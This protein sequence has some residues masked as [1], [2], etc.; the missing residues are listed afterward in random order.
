MPENNIITEEEIKKIMDMKG[1]KN[2]RNY[3][4]LER[5]RRLRRLNEAKRFRRPSS[6]SLRPSRNRSRGRML[7]GVSVNESFGTRHYG[8]KPFSHEDIYGLRDWIMIS[9]EEEGD[10]RFALKKEMRQATLEDLDD[11]DFSYSEMGIFRHIDDDG[12]EYYTLAGYEENGEFENIDELI[13]TLS[14]VEFDSLYSFRYW[15]GHNQIIEV[16]D[17]DNVSKIEAFV[18]DIDE[19]TIEDFVKDIDGDM[20]IYD[21]YEYVL[22]I[23]EYEK[24]FFCYTY[25]YSPFFYHDEEDKEFEYSYQAGDEDRDIGEILNRLEKNRKKLKNFL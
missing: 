20:Q 6:N 22:F 13:G 4:F 19:D 1:E 9:L 8:Y 3:D 15:D 14:D 23:P 18:K 16:Y 7:R 10:R 11:A 24:A 2:M 21:K 12:E 5:S 17:E 25:D